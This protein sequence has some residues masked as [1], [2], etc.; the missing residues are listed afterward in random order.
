MTTTTHQYDKVVEVVQQQSEQIVPAST[1]RIEEDDYAWYRA[2][3]GKPL[4]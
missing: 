4:S 2:H 3:T 1:F